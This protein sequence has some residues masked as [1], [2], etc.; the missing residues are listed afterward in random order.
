M[1]TGIGR[2]SSLPKI[3]ILLIAHDEDARIGGIEGIQEHYLSVQRNFFVE[4]PN[5]IVFRSKFKAKGSRIRTSSQDH[6]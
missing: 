4:N 1:Q 3:G 2:T 6:E 5:L